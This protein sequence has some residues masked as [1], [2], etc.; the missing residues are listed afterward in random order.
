[1]FIPIK[2]KPED[3]RFADEFVRKYGDNS[4][5]KQFVEKEEKNS[6]AI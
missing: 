6:L 5:T 2:F 3:Q 1:M 4:T